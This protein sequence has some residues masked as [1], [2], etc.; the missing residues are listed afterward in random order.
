MCIYI[1]YIYMYIMYMIYVYMYIMYNLRL[2]FGAWHQRRIEVGPAA[3]ASG[4][5]TPKTS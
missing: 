1:C 5:R 2:F 3:V 4:D